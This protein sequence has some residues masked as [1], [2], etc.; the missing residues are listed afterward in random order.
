[1]VTQHDV[2]ELIC[3]EVRRFHEDCF[4]ESI[5][6]E[7]VPKTLIRASFPLASNALTKAKQNQ[8]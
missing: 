6:F 2:G 3:K 4:L 7:A 1:M 8:T 5:E